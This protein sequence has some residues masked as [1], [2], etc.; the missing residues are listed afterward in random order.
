MLLQVNYFDL[1]GPEEYADI[2]CEF[3][4]DTSGVLLVFDVT[5]RVSYTHLGKWLDE[6]K[7]SCADIFDN[8]AVVVCGNKIDLPRRTVM[9]AE[10]RLWC[11]T[12]GMYY[13]DTSAKV[14]G[15]H[16]SLSSPRSLSN[17]QHRWFVSSPLGDRGAR[18][19]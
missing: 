9:E 13:F 18:S 16:S 2:R 14:C 6:L 8:A 12:R 19:G 17:G 15:I 4:P 1:A 3:F 10:A 5:N 7:G 11:E